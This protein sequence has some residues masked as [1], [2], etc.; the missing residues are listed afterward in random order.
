MYTTSSKHDLQTA[1]GSEPE[2]LE[3]QISNGMH[4]S[5]V[6]RHHLRTRRKLVFAKS[7][8]ASIIWGRMAQHRL[9]AEQARLQVLYSRT[10]PGTG[11]EN[12][13]ATVSLAGSQSQRWTMLS[14]SPG[15]SGVSR[16]CR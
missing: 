9:R 3:Y 2:I 16:D 11:I 12:D 10:T 15:S 8:R 7:E 6:Y 14:R 13:A 1:G 4:G 5:D